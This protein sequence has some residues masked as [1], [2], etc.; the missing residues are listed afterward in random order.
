[1][2]ARRLG[3]ERIRWGAIKGWGGYVALRGAGKGRLVE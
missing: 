3:K 2:G 1:M